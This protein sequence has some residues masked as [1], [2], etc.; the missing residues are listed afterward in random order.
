M[1]SVSLKRLTSFDYAVGIGYLE[2]WVNPATVA[3]VEP[4]R[5]FDS[6]TDRHALDGTR[7]YFQQESGVLDVKEPIG[8]VVALLQSG[9]RGLCTD[10]YQELPEAWMTLCAACR[11][12]RHCGVDEIIEEVP[13]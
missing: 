9:T 4:R 8:A 12:H 7:L 3:Y 2:V 11:E 6:K 13:A 10:C 1:N 5:R